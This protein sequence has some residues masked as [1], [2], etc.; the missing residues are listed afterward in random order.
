MFWPLRKKVDYSGKHLEL[1]NNFEMPSYAIVD[2]MMCQYC[3]S[4]VQHANNSIP[5]QKIFGANLQ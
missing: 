4:L 1:Y 5:R 2:T 3:L